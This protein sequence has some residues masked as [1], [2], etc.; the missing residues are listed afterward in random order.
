[1]ALYNDMRPTTF[2]EVFGQDE[3]VKIL[4]AVLEQ[5]EAKRPRVFL[6]T[7]NYGCGKTTLASVFA[8]A[9]GITKRMD[10]QVLDASRDR[11]I[12]SIRAF[13]EMWG[14]HP[15]SREAQGRVY[16]LDECHSLTPPAFE[17]LLKKCE[18]VPPKT[19]IFFCTTEENKVP[20]P[21]R[22]RC[23]VIPI[24]PMTPKAIYN[25]LKHVCEKTGYSA[26]DSSLQEIATNSDSSARV[27]LQILEN[28]MLNGGD[29]KKAIDLQKGFSSKLEADTITLCRAI[30]SRSSNWG[31]VV[32]FLKAYKGQDEP[33]R[34]A[35]LN[36]LYACLLNSK[37]DS[38]RRRITNIMECFLTPF[39]N[40][41]KAGLAYMLSNAMDCK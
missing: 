4:K 17:A 18:D 2:D 39:F 38:D 36:Y 29:V 22:S 8:R 31:M 34:I 7:G 27:S 30:I 16:V 1:M 11:G 28:M 19:Y 41:D 5:D 13:I 24:H 23:K 12:D 40:A 3:A 6:L 32:E 37:G 26:E 25:N 21:L 15:M 35:I 14:T 20:K 9:I 33:V 10:F